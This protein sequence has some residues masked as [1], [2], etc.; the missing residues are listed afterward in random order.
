MLNP[1]TMKYLLRRVILEDRWQSQL[2]D[3]I[4]LCRRV[5]IEE[6]LLLEQSHQMLMA[7]WP[8]ER[9]RRMAEIY[10]QMAD[11]LRRHGIGF[12]VNVGTLVGHGDTWVT[13]PYL[14]PYQRF[15]G[16]DLKPAHA[17]YCLLDEG[18][19][20]YAARVCGLYA[21]GQPDRLFVDDDFRT[22]NH[23]APVGCFCPIHARQ[24]GKALEVRLTSEELLR[25]IAG[26]SAEDRAVRETW[27][28]MNFEGMLAAARKIREAVAEVSPKTRVG[29][30][31]SNEEAHALQG[32]DNDRLLREFVGPGR[33]PLTRPGGGAYCDVVHGEV[34]MTHQRMALD[35]S[36]LGADVEIVSEVENYPHTRFSKSVAFTRLQM[37][38]HALAGA[39]GMTLN[40]YDYLATPFAREPEWEKMLGEI[41]APLARVAAAVKGKRLRGFGLPW[42]RE[43]ALHR[44]WGRGGASDLL[45]SRP[46]DMLLPQFGLPVQ[47]TP[48]EGNALLGTDVMAYNDAEIRDFL[49]GGLLLDA[50]AAELLGGR[51]FEDQVGCR[52]GTKLP[53]ASAERLDDHDWSGPFRGDLMT[54]K[55]ADK[56][57]GAPVPRRLEPLP[58]A[59]GI[60]T[61][62]DAELV[63]TGAGTVIFDNQLGGRVAVVSAPVHAWTWFYRSRA[64]LMGKIIRWLMCERL[65]VWIEDS[66]NVGVFFYED[67]KTGEGLAA[68]INAGVDPAPVR[69]CGPRS[70][71]DL[72]SGKERDDRS[73]IRS[74]EI[75]FFTSFPPAG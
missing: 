3:L 9:H 8:M 54:V 70:W 71:S 44:V 46:L 18:W 74:F 42:R 11:E 56:T 29:L 25:R 38:L 13:E 73:E 10:R 75:Q 41:K 45:P 40:I 2:A 4:A 27:M 37:F 23:S 15:V 58:G 62:L 20:E 28:R 47:F 22:M 7:P 17:C 55:L 49:K 64:W 65:P 34:L 66:P 53:M 68:V 57:E 60:S 12:G 61:L 36:V 52:V 33:R 6:V 48:S 24:T 1:A 30:M 26:T 16:S 69:L 14:L 59:R 63:E 72:W 21:L 43:M 19:Q 67:P 51:G 5:P 35:V 39:E 32:R 31:I 50:A